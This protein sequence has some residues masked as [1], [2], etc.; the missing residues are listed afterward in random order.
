V[1]TVEDARLAAL[2]ALEVEVLHYL[3]HTA[4]TR[5]PAWNQLHGAYIVSRESEP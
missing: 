1:A 3:R 2:E 5:I 4:H